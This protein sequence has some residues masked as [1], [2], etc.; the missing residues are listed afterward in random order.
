VLVINL[1]D[2]LGI[3]SI[4]VGFLDFGIDAH[5]LSPPLDVDPKVK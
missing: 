1:I 5:V 2:S 3:K 4:S